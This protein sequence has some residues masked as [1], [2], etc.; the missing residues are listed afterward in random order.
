GADALLGYPRSAGSRQLAGQGQGGSRSDGDEL[1]VVYGAGELNRDGDRIGG[2][3]RL[4]GDESAA[5]GDQGI[6]EREGD[7]GASADGIAAGRLDLDRV[8]RQAGNV[9]DGGVK[10]RGGSAE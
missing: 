5:A 4:V 10:T 7:A 2:S 8:Y 3:R 6:P 1:L 9:V